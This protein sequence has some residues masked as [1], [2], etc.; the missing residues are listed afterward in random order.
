LRAYTAEEL[1]ELG[2]PAAHKM[3]WR[4]GYTPM[5][6]SPGLLTYLVGWPLAAAESRTNSK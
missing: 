4:S 2:A 3:Y 5:V 1:T 6:A